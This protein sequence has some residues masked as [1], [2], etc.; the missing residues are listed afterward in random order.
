MVRLIPAD[1]VLL[2]LFRALRHNE[3]VVLAAD[4]TVTGSG[5]WV[6][7]FGAPAKL[8]DS[9]VRLALR[10][11]AGLLMAFGYRRPRGRFL[12]RILRVSLERTG[13]RELDLGQGMEA[14]V[15]LLERQIRAHPEQWILTKPLWDQC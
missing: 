8:P 4:R 12:L 7:F 14:V 15:A 13:G 6:K 1:G 10:T 5:R 9:A 11:G 3:A 2:G